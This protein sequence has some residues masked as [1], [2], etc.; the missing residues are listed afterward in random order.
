MTYDLEP[1]SFVYNRTG[2]LSKSTTLNTTIAEKFMKEADIRRD[3]IILDSG[4]E[5]ERQSVSVGD[6]ILA[7]R[8]IAPIT[9]LTKKIL[10]PKKYHQVELVDDQYRV[11]IHDKIIDADINEKGYESRED[12]EYK[13]LSKIKG[14]VR[15]SVK[16]ILFSEKLGFHEHM[17]F[18]FFYGLEAANIISTLTSQNFTGAAIN[19]GITFFIVPALNNLHAITSYRRSQHWDELGKHLFK[20]YKGVPLNPILNPRPW[21]KA[22]YPLIPVDKWIKGNKVLHDHG[23]D[24][25]IIR[26][27]KE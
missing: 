27:E 3:I 1:R 24:L 14:E 18:Y 26:N 12:Y 9:E 25:I 6:D 23:S 8:T 17:F 22:F 10:K 19:A 15:D 20:D 2:N 4:K 16:E 21:N 11:L 7:W 13:F 5:P